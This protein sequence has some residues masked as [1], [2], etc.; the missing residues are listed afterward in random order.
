MKYAFFDFI[1]I[2]NILMVMNT[3]I[4]PYWFSS[5]MFDFIMFY[6]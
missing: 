4:A 2:S 6:L 5:D 1:I 3:I